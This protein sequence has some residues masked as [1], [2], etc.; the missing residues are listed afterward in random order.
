MSNASSKISSL[1][2]L[3]AAGLLIVMA[4]L[5]LNDPDPWYWIA[6]YV[7]AATI[8]IRQLINR[9]STAAYWVVAGMI[10]SGLLIAAPGLTDYIS[11]GNWGAITGEMMDHISY[12][13]SAR[14]F[15]GLA[16]AACLLVFYRPKARA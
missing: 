10:L 15:G 16:I 14:E 1:G 7:L 8:P 3:A 9:P 6:V 4:G 2:H 12:V 5:Q 11:S 13:E